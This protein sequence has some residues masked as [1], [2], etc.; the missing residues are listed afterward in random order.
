MDPEASQL[1]Q[2]EG[3]GPWHPAMR[4]N[5]HSANTEYIQQAEGSSADPSLVESKVAEFI[6]PED[7]VD[8]P[9]TPSPYH[10][11][12]S[13]K[14][15]SQQDLYQKET[16]LDLVDHRHTASVS[17]DN[18]KSRD[19]ESVREDAKIKLHTS[20]GQKLAEAA[21]TDGL[22][23]RPQFDEGSQIDGLHA[24]NS[25]D[26]TN[27]DP[28]SI[29]PALSAPNEKEANKKLDMVEDSQ[30]PSSLLEDF[31]TI[32]RTNSF[33]EVPPLR[34]PD[35]P[36]SH[37]LA[38]SQAQ[39]LLEQ[40]ETP[41][42]FQSGKELIANE[43][44][45][46]SDPFNSA[47]NGDESSFFANIGG[48]HSEVAKSPVDEEARFEEGLPLMPS[49][50]NVYHS[51]NKSSGLYDQQASSPELPEVFNGGSQ[52]ASENTL[53]DEPSF[54]RPLS[55][56]RKSTSQVLDSLQYTSTG[57]NHTE[58]EKK[59]HENRDDFITS[60]STR[61]PEFSSN[62]L[63]G[64]AEPNEE[65]NFFAQDPKDDDL[66]AEWQ[67]ALGDDEL[68]DE[69]E[70]SV[71]PATFFDDDGE[72]FL[73]EAEDAIPD[74]LQSQQDSLSG[75]TEQG[76]SDPDSGNRS[77]TT[78]QHQYTPASYTQPPALSSS[79]YLPATGPTQRL[80]QATFG[81]GHSISAPGGFNNALQQQSSPG[82]APFPARPKMPQSTQSF[83][84]KSKGG[85]TSPYDLPMDVTRPKKRNY[86]QQIQA[87]PK[88]QIT[89]N[90]MAPPRSSSIYTKGTPSVSTPPPLPS[91]SGAS[92]SPHIVNAIHPTL[93]PTQSFFEELPSVKPRPASSMGRAALRPQISPP[94]QVPPQYDPSRPNPTRSAS[95]SSSM[96]QTYQLVPPE[97]ISPYANVSSQEPTTQPVPALNSRYSPAPASQQTVPPPRNRY[98]S[99]PATGPR[100][101]QPAQIL[102]FQPRTSSPL[103][104]Q[105][106][107]YSSSAPGQQ[108]P[109]QPSITETSFPPLIHQQSLAQEH[110][111]SPQSNRPSPPSSDSRYTPSSNSPPSSY[112]MRAHDSNRLPPSNLPY[113][114][115]QELPQSILDDAIM[116]PPRRSQTQS[117]SAMRSR[118][119][120]YPNAK[121][122]HHRPASVNQTSY[123]DDA[124]RLSAATYQPERR[125]D[126]I[127]PAVNYIRPTDG[128]ENDYLE[129]WQGCPI[130]VFG[131]GGTIVSSFPK[132]IP[133]YAAGQSIPMMKCSPGE[134]KIHTGK[135]FALEESIATFPGPLRSKNKKKE[136]LDWLQKRIHELENAQ[137]PIVQAPTLPDP[138][139]RNEEKIIL[140]RVVQTLV[141]SDGAIEGNPTAEKA[142]RT[143]LSPELAVGDDAKPSLYNSNAPLIGITRSRG[144]V[145]V[146]GLADSKALESL[147]KILLHGEREEAVWH[148]VDRR[149]WGHAM[150]LASTLDKS[151]W[152]QVLQEFN[153]QEVKA[154]G[155]NTESLAALYQVFAGNWEE[156]VDQLVPPSA[157]AGLQMV[158]KAS[159]T[160][161]MKNALDGLDRWRETL[162]LVLS[163]RTQEDGNALL[164]LGRLLAGYGR[165]EAAHVCYIFAK[166]P[167]LFGG[168]DD[169]QVSVALLGADHLQHPYDYS[170]DFDSILLTEV[171]DYAR[172]VLA[173]SAVVTVSPHLQSYK[174]YHALT[175][176]EYGYRSEAQS[177]CDTITS[178]LKSTTKLSPYYHTLLFGAL[179]DLVQR[180]RQAPKDGSTSMIAGLSMDK[181]S[182]SVWSRLN[183]FIA[184]DES[185]AES[186]KSG[187]V[188]DPA[189]GPFARIAGD[190]PNI[191][192]PPSSN[193]L[194]S[195]YTPMSGI[196]PPQHT[197]M[198]SNSRYAPAGPYT[199]RSSLEQ[200]NQPSQDFQRPAQAEVLRPPLTQQ[201]N[202][203]DRS[204]SAS[205]RSLQGQQQQDLYKPPSQP[206]VCTPPAESY[207]PT[208]PSQPQY[209][210]TAPPDELSS[211]LYQQEPYQPS[212]SSEPKPYQP[213]SS[214]E[215]QPSQESYQP[216]QT[217]REN[218]SYT[219]LTTNKVPPS[220]SYDPGQ[221]SYEPPGYG[222]EPPSYDPENEDGKESPEDPKSPKEKSFI[223][224]DDGDDDF[225]AKAA[226]V[227]RAQK[228]QKDR[229]ADEAFKKAAEAD[230]EL[231]SQAA[232]KTLSIIYHP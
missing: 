4:P 226:A 95:N 89:T 110:R 65:I 9:F 34:H 59:L 142:V 207:L 82:G 126:P 228:A 32:D 118:P 153:T 208:P 37:P 12:P 21:S 180:L 18:Y 74:S 163:N 39:D 36:P 135:A 88:S 165:T 170:R 202:F 70:S 171:Y 227:L 229:E 3:L 169:P 181:V 121:I 196:P 125:R 76:F 35:P 16:P 13:I 189:T 220:S 68:L 192:R 128:R 150:L 178:A 215:P 158:S 62:D 222:Y 154:Y 230:G 225:A 209:M 184:G 40:D 205:T 22:P 91:V 145:S 98:A 54:F 75:R 159:T 50:S 139:K 45:E 162:T 106:T 69:N 47:A 216:D 19:R 56:D 147:R 174:L 166:I 130:F 148:A 161:P 204:K 132:Q 102:P 173:P 93:K 111:E 8:M 23:V 175:L 117:P 109:R 231:P 190:S 129:R 218:Y 46:A 43:G 14:D 182:G 41:Y 83:A 78:S 146:P 217:F 58:P 53:S 112:S 223:Y 66:A 107:S 197:T 1:G 38:H 81:M 79:Q 31:G 28:K 168:P 200:P 2:D 120:V 96:S 167:G 61:I 26:D 172:T 27:G 29:L 198:G 127:T 48:L 5:L 144:S 185:D 115:T 212:P 187:N 151:V 140:W 210:P 99:S 188:H 193:D 84:D 131:F 119:D 164:A 104:T 25:A 183:Q 10:P 221:S 72:G 80:P 52:E 73:E 6:P 186:T 232:A 155:D 71:D 92:P 44:L 213:S 42:G 77:A 123:M 195:S 15:D 134:V 143:I 103:A 179:E 101:P 94:R 138:R 206:S 156:S 51:T 203:L 113:S 87:G 105:N 122:P 100:P 124:A 60:K 7:P 30:Q 160:G 49:G 141:E 90:T 201:L 114:N 63:E 33:P 85:Y 194:Y 152:K 211:S 224:G 17:N 214:S 86:T 137:L 199:P 64:S 55:L 24:L 136:V 20:D 149:L 11:L 177:Y 57:V 97:R 67:A 176:A 157:R 133:R 191:S 219:P 108:Q 116:G